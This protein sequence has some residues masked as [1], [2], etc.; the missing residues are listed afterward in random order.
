MS[1]STDYFSYINIIADV[2]GNM[3]SYLC[4]YKNIKPSES[5]HIS[6]LIDII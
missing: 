2:F 1:N 5:D 6:Y 3:Y 4:K